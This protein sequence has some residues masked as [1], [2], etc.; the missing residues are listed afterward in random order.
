MSL[1]RRE[2]PLHERLAEQGGLTVPT[3]ETRD[4]A[5]WHQAGVHGVPRPRRW[6]AVVTAEADLPGEAVHFVTLADR[7]V[8]VDEEVPEGALVPLADA[9]ETQVD[10]P[11]RAE[12]T[13]RHHRLWAVGASRITVAELDEEIAGDTVELAARD[14]VVTLLVD[15]A[16]AFGSVRALEALGAGMPSYVVR[17]ERVDG[18]LWEVLVLPL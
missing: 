16:H 10:P 8:V 4:V 3:E 18:D 12:G 7:S 2:K 6:D 14:G 11:Y 17:A 15:G 1:W 13:R 9:I 5:P